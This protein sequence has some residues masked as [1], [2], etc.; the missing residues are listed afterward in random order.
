MLVRKTFLSFSFSNILFSSIDL[1]CAKKKFGD[2]R[3]FDFDT[4][5]WR[6]SRLGERE[7]GREKARRNPFHFTRAFLIFYSIGVYQFF[8]VILCG[9]NVT[10]TT[11]TLPPSPPLVSS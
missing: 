8:I 9:E 6:S 2:E 3:V 10:T 11:A 4:F 1:A 5:V 7:G